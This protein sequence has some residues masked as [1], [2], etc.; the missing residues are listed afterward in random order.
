MEHC[1]VVWNI[2]VMTFHILGMS[3]SQLTNSIIFQ[4]GIGST[5]NQMCFSIDSYWKWPFIVDLPIKNGGYFHWTWMTLQKKASPKTRLKLSEQIMG[6]GAPWVMGRLSH[7]KPSMDLRSFRTSMPWRCQSFCPVWAFYRV[8]AQI[9]WPSQSDPGISQFVSCKINV[10]FCGC[11]MTV[12]HT[13]P[14][15]VGLFTITTCLVTLSKN[16]FLEQLIVYIYIWYIY[17]YV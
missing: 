6:S 9:F 3:S 16:Q 4:R 5:T 1:L 12:L 17:I 13:Y 7:P 15:K 2:N 11:H 14:M 10:F 8:E